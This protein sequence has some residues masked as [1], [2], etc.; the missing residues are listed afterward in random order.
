VYTRELA[1]VPGLTVQQ[2]TVRDDK[3]RGLVAEILV[4]GVVDEA[5]IAKALLGMAVP[6]EVKKAQL[7]SHV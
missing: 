4:A 6:Y 2:I 7:E 5:V 1:A 3:Q